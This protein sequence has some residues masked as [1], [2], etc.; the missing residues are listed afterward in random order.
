MSNP[1][2]EALSRLMISQEKKTR[3]KDDAAQRAWAVVREATGQS[4]DSDIEES[5][6]PE[7]T[8]T[9]E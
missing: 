1:D 8:N 9:D 6:V 5:S 2:Q 4:E 7:A 3:K